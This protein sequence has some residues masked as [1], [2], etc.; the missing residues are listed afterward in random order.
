MKILYST[1]SVC[2]ECLK[3]KKITKFIPAEVFEN[4]GKI[5]IQKTCPKHGKIKEMIWSDAKSYHKIMTSLYAGDGVSNPFIKTSNCPSDC[6]LCPAH[7][8]HTLLGLIDV[9]NRCNIRCWYCFANASASGF[10]YEPS[11]K[12]IYQ[13]L[14]NL[15][16]ERPV[17]CPAVQFSGG[18]PLIRKDL[19]KIIKKA[20]ELG[21]KQIQIATNGIMLAKNNTLTK[22][23]REAGLNTIYLKWNGTNKNTNIENLVYKDKILNN[24]RK[25]GLGIVL[26]PT[27]IKTFNDKEVGNIIKFAADNS[28]IIRGVNFQP[29]SF[30]GKLKN[31]DETKRKKEAYNIAD[32]LKDIKE[33]INIDEKNFFAVPTV[34]PISKFIAALK[35]KPQAEFGAH[36][37][38]GM[39][40]Y[41]F[42][43]N[44]KIYPLPE[45]I[46]IEGFIEFIKQKTKKVE[47][48][49]K[50]ARF[51]V[52]I[53]IW[54][55]MKKFINK[56]KAPEGF[57]M[58]KIIF[59]IM[60][61]N[62]SALAKFHL[63]ALYIGAMRFQDAWTMDHERLRRCCIHFCSPDGR[64]IPFC[65]Y[66]TFPKYRKEIEKQ[67]GIP[68]SEWKKRNPKKTIGSFM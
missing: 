52:Y 3:R 66:N 62:F 21:F 12:Q 57:N 8:S 46:D 53:S 1:K 37:L 64:I 18:E 2:P 6:G 30:V 67:F 15:R 39:A 29:I 10:V 59:E 45:F 48:G 7:K 4:R 26:V 34:I 5:Y 38:C 25:C 16:N 9:T 61:G 23:L 40:S 68:L 63:N 20:K 24:C 19:V 49:K 33:Q 35:K 43:K 55:N 54:K 32:L 51:F 56:K 14:E 42:I 50:I 58:T 17:K 13:M 36:P 41:L 11:L 22:E 60:K 47:N 44:G 31:I 65:S 27:I 28:D